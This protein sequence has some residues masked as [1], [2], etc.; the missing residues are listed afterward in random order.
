MSSNFFRKVVYDLYYILFLIIDR[1]KNPVEGNKVAE[2][3]LEYNNK[4]VMQSLKG[5]TVNKLLI[6]LPHCVQKYTC[7]YKVTSQIENCRECGQCVIGE[8]LKMK[9]KYPIDVRIATGGTLARKHIKETRPDLVAAV[10][11]KRDLMSGIHDAFPVKVYGIF[12]KIVNEPCVDTTVSTEKIKRFLEEIYKTQ[13][14][15]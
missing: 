9:K 4:K 10:A 1:K 13:E 11:C 12:N 3:F 8:L 14:E 6:L 2:R 7:P 15:A 5:K